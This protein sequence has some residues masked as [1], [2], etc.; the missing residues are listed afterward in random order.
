MS[1]S[2]KSQTSILMVEWEAVK[3]AMKAYR[4]NTR[5]HYYNIAPLLFPAADTPKLAIHRLSVMRGK[6]SDQTPDIGEI[7]RV[8]ALLVELNK[9]LSTRQTRNGLDGN[10]GPARNALDGFR[11]VGP[12]NNDN[13]KRQR[14]HG[15]WIGISGSSFKPGKFTIFSLD[16]EPS[17][18][19]FNV[20]YRQRDLETHELVDYTGNA[21]FILNQLWLVF[22]EVRGL[23]LTIMQL[24]RPDTQENPKSM[25]GVFMGRGG[26]LGD[27]HPAAG[28]VFLTRGENRE[29]LGLLLKDGWVTEED[30]LKV[31]SDR[32]T[33]IILDHVKGKVKYGDHVFRAKTVKSL[34]G[35][36]SNR[37][38]SRLVIEP[39]PRSE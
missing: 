38:A 17:E 12:D 14:F 5:L 23:E 21:Y 24:Q 22:E 13:K 18:C 39:L 20:L 36:T 27:Q 25:S 19:G 37:P 8:T 11:I 15:S 3:D 7:R 16:L 34:G 29:Q 9:D 30:I 6:R 1:E 4:L 28:K 31:C 26:G 32:S 35:A 33:R 10:P 2:A